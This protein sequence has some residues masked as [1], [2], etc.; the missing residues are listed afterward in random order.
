MNSRAIIKILWLPC[1]LVMLAGAMLFWRKSDLSGL[2]RIYADRELTYNNKNRLLLLTGDFKKQLADYHEQAKII[3]K[4]L[5]SLDEAVA[6]IKTI[7]KTAENY[8]VRLTDFEYDIPKYLQQR[9]STDNSGAITIPFEGSFAGKYIAMGKFIE[10][11]EKKIYLV[12]IYDMKFTNDSNAPSDV[13]CV[14][15]GALRFID[16]SKLEFAGYGK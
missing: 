7:A 14:F 13:N 2:D 3:Q 11:L 16:R 15:K 5:F 4:D 10:E 6:M 1:L 8:Q 12:N 9:R